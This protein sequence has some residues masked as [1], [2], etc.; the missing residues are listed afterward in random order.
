MPTFFPAS[1]FKWID[2]KEFDLNNKMAMKCL[3][4]ISV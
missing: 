4:K 3:K 1:G 2:T